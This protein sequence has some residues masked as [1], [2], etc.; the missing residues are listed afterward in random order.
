MWVENTSLE[1]FPHI[2]SLD[3]ELVY[4]AYDQTFRRA[5]RVHGKTFESAIL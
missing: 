2:F 1:R 4:L 3:E 5:T